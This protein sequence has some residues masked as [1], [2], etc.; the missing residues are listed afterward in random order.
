MKEHLVQQ[1]K[2]DYWANK[3][4]FD[5]IIEH[6]VQDEKI[7]FWMNHIVNAE[8]VWF[9]RIRTGT[10][11][12]SPTRV[13]SMEACGNLMK[14]LNEEIIEMLDAATEES[15]YENISY[16]N[17]RSI[18]FQNIVKDILAHLINHSTHHRA[19]I[20]ARLREKGIAPPATDYIFYMR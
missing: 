20:A 5:T 14:N 13:Q 16:S 3:L 9:E 18:A 8:H 17:T 19:Q 11:S 15:L 10:S 1:F 12:V 7:I 4:I 6:Q 2:Y